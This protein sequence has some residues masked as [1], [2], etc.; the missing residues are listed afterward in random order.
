MTKDHSAMM[1][2]TSNPSAAPGDATLFMHTRMNGSQFVSPRNPEIPETSLPTISVER[3]RYLPEDLK[4][5][6]LAALRSSH[7]KQRK[8]AIQEDDATL[9]R[10]ATAKAVV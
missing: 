1:V 4:R 6:S 5:H 2:E 7:G 3:K 10:S 9:G 8:S